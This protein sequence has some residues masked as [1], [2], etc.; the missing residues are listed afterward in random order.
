VAGFT[1]NNGRNRPSARTAHESLFVCVISDSALAPIL[2]ARRYKYDIP[3]LHVN[4]VYMAKH[5]V[6]AGDAAA[7]LAASAAGTF[8]APRGE[9]NATK[10]EVLEDVQSTSTQTKA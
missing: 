6:T 10:Y 5:R 3:V 8:E 9:P 4:G 7:A 2:S 1:P